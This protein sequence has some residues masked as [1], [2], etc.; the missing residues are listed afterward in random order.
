MNKYFNRNTIEE[1]RERTVRKYY[2]FDFVIFAKLLS[3]GDL[4][5]FGHIIVDL[6]DLQHKLYTYKIANT[7]AK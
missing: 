7:E 2:H 3:F 5:I 1:I 4:A 6:L